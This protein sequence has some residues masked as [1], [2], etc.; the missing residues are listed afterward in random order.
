MKAQVLVALLAAIMI[1]GSSRNVTADDDRSTAALEAARNA[2]AVEFD[3]AIER[4]EKDRASGNRLPASPAV[5]RAEKARFEKDGSVPWSE[6]MRPYLNRYLQALHASRDEPT[7][8]AV[9]KHQ[10]GNGAH[11]L[12]SNGKVNDSAGIPTWSFTYGRLVF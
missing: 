5:V 4:L 9:W 3:R 10:P 7:V 8:I 1:L 6:P 2:L 12:Y 11:R